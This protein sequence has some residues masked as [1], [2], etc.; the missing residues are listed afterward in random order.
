MRRKRLVTPHTK[1]DYP[2]LS[3]RNKHS[4]A[5]LIKTYSSKRREGESPPQRGTHERDIE[6]MMRGRRNKLNDEY[7]VTRYLISMRRDKLILEVLRRC[8]RLG[9]GGIR[10][11]EKRTKKNTRSSRRWRGIGGDVKANRTPRQSYD[12]INSILIAE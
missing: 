11:R 9:S 7:Y 2:E 8:A 10:A 12:H 4:F 6:S 1:F 3:A 5:A